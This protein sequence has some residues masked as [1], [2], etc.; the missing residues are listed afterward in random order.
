MRLTTQRLTLEPISLEHLVASYGYSSD[1][2]NTGYM[3]F[4]PYASIGEAE[5]YIRSC[6]EMWGREQPEYLEFAVQL[7]GDHI[8]RVTLYLPETGVGELGWILDKR[9][10]RRGYAGEAVRAVMD[11]G[12]KTWGIRRFIAMCDSENAPSYRLMERLGMYP[13]GRAGGRKNRSS[14]EERQE[15]TYEINV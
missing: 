6:M 13:V 1:P 10:W 9:Y 5:E 14:Q 11:Y 15:L 4:L 2:E 3:M 7:G 8:G 12:R